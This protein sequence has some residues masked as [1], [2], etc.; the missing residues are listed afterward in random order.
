MKTFT[1]TFIKRMNCNILP[2]VFQTLKLS[3]KQSRLERTCIFWG[4]IVLI[5]TMQVALWSVSLLF[6]T[7]YP[8]YIWLHLLLKLCTTELHTTIIERKVRACKRAHHMHLSIATPDF[9]K[10][11]SHLL[12]F[13]LFFLSCIFWCCR[14]V[15][16]GN[17]ITSSRPG[18]S[19]PHWNTRLDTRTS[20]HRRQ[21]SSLK[22]CS[23]LQ[24]ASLHDK[25]SCG[26]TA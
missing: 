11:L 15:F 9:T 4:K 22:L 18:M 26:W 5:K 7:H 3:N 20:Q 16:I 8:L 13:F 23:C 6:C 10:S 21:S 17:Q 25:A 1:Q 12:L 2:C 19:F 24:Q 14:K